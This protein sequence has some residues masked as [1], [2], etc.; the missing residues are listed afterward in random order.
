MTF[1]EPAKITTDIINFYLNG[2]GF[3][4]ENVNSFGL[5]MSDSII[6]FAV[7]HFTHLVRKVQDIFTYRFDYKGSFTIAKNMTKSRVDTGV[8]HT[9]ELQYL[10]N[11]NM[12][13][14]YSSDNKEYDMV[15]FMTTVW[16]QFA[17]T[18]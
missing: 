8:A 13:P 4:E 2:T 5:L 1:P 10:F 9:D 12:Y 18:G 11:T 17:I 7:A 14:K 16:Y 3:N 15:N 6:N